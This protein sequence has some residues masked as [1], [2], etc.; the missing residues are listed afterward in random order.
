MLDAKT[1]TNVLFVLCGVSLLC[2]TFASTV[3]LLLAVIFDFIL[4][5]E[6][7]ALRTTLWAICL[8]L[9]ILFFMLPVCVKATIHAAL[10]YSKYRSTEAPHRGSWVW[11]K[12]CIK[13][14]WVVHSAALLIVF[15]Y[16]RYYSGCG[17][18]LII[19]VYCILVSI[20]TGN[21]YVW[22][23]CAGLALL[24]LVSMSLLSVATV[25]I[26]LFESYRES[27][28]PL[29]GTDGCAITDSQELKDPYGSNQVPPCPNYDGKFAVVC[30]TNTNVGSRNVTSGMGGYVDGMH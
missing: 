9:V 22:T 1:L 11:V 14:S 27:G 23:M 20:S 6:D 10:L 29:Q 7:D 18:L 26:L 30:G 19:N 21:A 3:C 8:I 28:E 2:E 15:S 25:S 13:L 4:E 17:E 12:S 24:L 5:P 16:W